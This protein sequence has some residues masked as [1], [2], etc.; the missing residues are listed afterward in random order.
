MIRQ[1]TLFLLNYLE[2]AQTVNLHCLRH[3]PNT[4]FGHNPDQSEEVPAI[5]FNPAAICS[6][7]ISA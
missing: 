1:S 6:F 5:A 3:V 4:S 2:A 7:H